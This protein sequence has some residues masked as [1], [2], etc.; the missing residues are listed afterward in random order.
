MGRDFRFLLEMRWSLTRNGGD[1]A[2]DPHASR[3][4]HTERSRLGKAVRAIFYTLLVTIV[5]DLMYVFVTSAWDAIQ[6]Y[7]EGMRLVT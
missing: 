4:K 6:S 2:N 5:A 3:P 7:L 1:C